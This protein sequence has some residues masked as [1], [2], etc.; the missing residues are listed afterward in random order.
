MLGSS[1]II[2]EPSPRSVNKEDMSRFLVVAWTVHPDVPLFLH[3]LELKHSKQCWA[4]GL[5]VVEIPESRHHP[6]RLT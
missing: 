4:R 3:V 6:L 5:E 2:F 1:C